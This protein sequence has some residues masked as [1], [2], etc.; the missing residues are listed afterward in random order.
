[1]KNKSNNTSPISIEIESSKKYKGIPEI[2]DLHYDLWTLKIT[3]EFT[4]LKNP[5]YLIFKN[6]GGFR[7]IDEGNL[8]EFWDNDDRSNGW[9]WKITKSGWHDQEKER[10]GFFTG[11]A[12]FKDYD[13]YMIAGIN[14][15]LNI[16]TNQEPEFLEP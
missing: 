4:D 1:M 7:V 2:T 13:E 14:D 8:L 12:N 6:V 11:R 15:C 16:I 10:V 9:L 3:L 5:I